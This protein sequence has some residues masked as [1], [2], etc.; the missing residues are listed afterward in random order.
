M[1]PAPLVALVLF[2]CAVD[3]DFG[4]TSFRCEEGLCPAGFVCVDFQ[5]VP[6]EIP[7]EDRVPEGLCG[8]VEPVS[9]LDDKFADG[10]LGAEWRHLSFAEGGASLGEDLEA[11]VRLPEDRP[12]R[13]VFVSSCRYD[14]ERG[15]IYVQMEKPCPRAC[16]PRPSSS[17][18][19]RARASGSPSPRRAATCEWR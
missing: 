17:S 16:T 3:G 14:L 12:S 18:S 9:E 11:I 5:C 8:D 10:S 6:D 19:A 1:R 7:G 15:W 13:G 2:G 4:G